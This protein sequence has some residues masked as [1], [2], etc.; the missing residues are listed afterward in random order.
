M[1]R[2]L[3]AEDPGDRYNLDIGNFQGGISCSGSSFDVWL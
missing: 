1:E 3:F 2:H